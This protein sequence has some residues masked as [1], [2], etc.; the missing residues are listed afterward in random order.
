MI[1]VNNTI[2]LPL[3]SEGRALE[4]SL[5]FQDHA[6]IVQLVSRPGTKL[7]MYMAIIK[8]ENW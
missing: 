5:C 1:I 6:L 4:I 8:V 7:A 2:L 3:Q